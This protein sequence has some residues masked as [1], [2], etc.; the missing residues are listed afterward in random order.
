M[1][2]KNIPRCWRCYARFKYNHPGAVAVNRLFPTSNAGKQVPATNRR[3][4]MHQT[5]GIKWLVDAA[6]HHGIKHMRS[7]SS[8]PVL[9]YL[10]CTF[11]PM[12]QAISSTFLAGLEAD[13]CHVCPL[14]GTSEPHQ[15]ATVCGVK[16][17]RPKSL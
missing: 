4:R 3:L 7:M 17:L 10:G 9:L 11:C 16:R 5:V 8:T 2:V 1:P 12:Q 6:G 14:A 13:Y 15:G